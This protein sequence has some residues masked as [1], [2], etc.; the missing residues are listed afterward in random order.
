VWDRFI[1][2][3]HAQ[4]GVTKDCWNTRCW[5]RHLVGCHGL[6][7]HQYVCTGM[8][9]ACESL[10]VWHILHEQEFYPYHLQCV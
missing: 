9:C 8:Y 3:H 10:T 2:A 4:H 5:G 1:E 7:I 6:S